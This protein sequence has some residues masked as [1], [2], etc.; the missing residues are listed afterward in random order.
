MRSVIGILCM[1]FL[2]LQGSMQC[3]STIT[4]KMKGPPPKL[5]QGRYSNLH[6]TSDCAWIRK[7]LYHTL[8]VSL[9]TYQEHFLRT[10]LGWLGLGRAPSEPCRSKRSIRNA[11]ISYYRRPPCPFH[12]CTPML[13]SKVTHTALSA[14]PVLWSIFFNKLCLFRTNGQRNKMYFSRWYSYVTCYT[15]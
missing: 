9:P 13:T 3:I 8:L 12:K 11:Y 6:W 15:S 14:S 5:F 7:P 1:I 2:Y 4:M 10:H